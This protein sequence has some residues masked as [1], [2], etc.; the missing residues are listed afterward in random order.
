MQAGGSFSTEPSQL[1]QAVPLIED[2]SGARHITRRSVWV[3][4][5]DPTTVS[6]PQSPITPFHRRGLRH[7]NKL[8]R[9][10]SLEQPPC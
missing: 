7:G 5:P 3:T 8:A 1:K 10:L 4:V 2:L 9:T 6:G